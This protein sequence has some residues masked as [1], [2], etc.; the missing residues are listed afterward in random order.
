MVRM[1][2]NHEACDFKGLHNGL[3]DVA[4]H[5]ATLL[6]HAFL[7]CQDHPKA[8]GREVLQ[9][10]KIQNQPFDVSQ[11]GVQFPLQLGSCGG[12]QTACQENGQRTVIDN[13]LIVMVMRKTSRMACNLCWVRSSSAV[14]GRDL[15]SCLRGSGYIAVIIQ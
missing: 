9:V 10:L 7:G 14:A 3:V 11:R 1:S 4:H 2:T 12:V 15:S 5:H 8:G 13:F 6:V